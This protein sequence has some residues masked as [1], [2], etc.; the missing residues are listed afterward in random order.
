MFSDPAEAGAEFYPH[1]HV[2]RREE[3]G[4]KKDARKKARFRVLLVV[5]LVCAIGLLYTV[6]ANAKRAGNEVI[7]RSVD[8]LTSETKRLATDL[9]NTIHTDQVIL[10]AMADLLA[11][12]DLSDYRNP[13]ALEIM[14][15]FDLEKTFISDLELLIP[16]GRVLC[17]SGIWYNATRELDFEEEKAKGAYISDREKNSFETGAYVM[18][19]A[20]PVV[21]DGETVAMLYSV[22]DLQ[23]ASRGYQTAA[24]DGHAFVLIVDGNTGDILLDTWHKKL[25]NIADL[26]GRK[27]LRGTRFENSVEGLRRGGSGDMSFISQTTGEVLYTHYEPMGINNWSVILGV[28]EKVALEG[29]RNVTLTLYK[30]TIIVGFIILSYLAYIV[31]YMH[32]IRR[33]V[34]L[35]GVTDQG[36]GLLN[37]VAYGHFLQKSEKQVISPAACIYIDA[38]GLHELNNA[39]GHE[40]G[41]RMLRAVADHLKEYFPKDGLY[42]VGGDEFVMFPSK[43][44]R[45]VCEARMRAVSEA[46]SAQG[47]SISYGIA[48][49]ESATGLRD[50]IRDADE[51]MLANKRAY[52]A[53]HDRRKPRS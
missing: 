40:A 28:P 45:D 5:T 41:D 33:D 17:R 9:A 1:T 43:A 29:T 26:G 21:R 36:T 8:E 30:M 51:R 23:N 10:M 50:L 25:G 47:Y 15:S 7:Q 49:H 20:V 4:M 22:V 39:Q 13:A 6:F 35:M 16:N 46:L 24:Y 3:R 32:Q 53:V 14:R 34:Y 37:S 42:R 44:D 27:A 31:W 38:N 48:I 12:Q 11:N 52:Y 19:N 18:R 2:N